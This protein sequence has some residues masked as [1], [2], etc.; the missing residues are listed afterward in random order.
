MLN[1]F[2]ATGLG[3]NGIS[4][5]QSISSS[6]GG[7]ASGAYV[8]SVAD[9][10]ATGS[11]NTPTSLTVTMNTGTTANTANGQPF[12]FTG[13]L[14]P[15]K[16]GG[17]RNFTISPAHDV[18]TSDP[19]SAELA[20]STWFMVRTSAVMS[21]PGMQ[22]M[23][24][25]VGARMTINSAGGNFI[26]FDNRSTTLN[27]QTLNP[28]GLANTGGGYWGPVMLLGQVTPLSSAT[29]PGA[30]LVLGDSIAAGTGD[31]PDSLGYEGYI[32]RSFENNIPFV[33]AARG[34][35]TAFAE[36]AH[37]DGQYALSIDT[38]ITDVLMELG[39]NDIEQFSLTAA[40]LEGSVASIATRYTNAGKRVWCFTVPP[41]T[42]SS[43]GWLSLPNQAFPYS[44]N[45]LGSSGAVA[46]SS[47]LNMSS[48]ANISVG[49]QVSLNGSSA[50]GIA[51]GTTV[52][53]VN[54]TNSTITLSSATTA[55]LSGSIQIYFGTNRSS[56]SPVETQRQAYNAFLRSSS[57]N[58]GCFGLIDV[59]SVMSDP[60]GSGKWRTD[61]GAA[62]RDGVHP[63]TVLHQAVINA[64][65]ISTAKFQVP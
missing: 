61:L 41:T 2:Q 25:P 23:D 28:S 38:G 49:L 24:V 8:A 3:A 53:A 4:L 36:A 62:S 56:A 48:V 21:A 43:D 9:G 6:G 52:T 44:V 22:L 30:V 42:Y 18:V 50:A 13:L 57:S 5:G 26:E 58:L 64:G 16:F 55:A 11:G 45:T 54:T 32:Q 34:S 27:D 14:V 59:D 51:P 31:T 12:T 15:V 33:T 37:S 35:T 40:E 7:I 10:F 17:A 63:S 1:S 29:P 65:L 19:T 20:P 39:R 47:V 46:G 60:A